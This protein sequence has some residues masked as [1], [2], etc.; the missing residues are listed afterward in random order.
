MGQKIRQN[1]SI[2]ICLQNKHVF[3]FYA[4]IQDGQQKWQENDLGKNS[5]V[6]SADSLWVKNFVKRSPVESS[7]TV[8]VKNFVEIAP[9][10]SVSEINAFFI[11]RRNSSWPPKVAEKPFVKKL[12]V[13][14]A[15]TLWVKNLVKIALS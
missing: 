11:L 1:R 14:S 6:V 12:P 3:G 2:L 7:Y 5:P 15:D 9:A 13:D 8:W 4:E 10:L